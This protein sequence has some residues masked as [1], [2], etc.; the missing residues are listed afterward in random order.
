M[1]FS[2]LSLVAF[3][4][5]AWGQD[6]PQAYFL[7]IDTSASMSETP[8]RPAVKEDWKTSKFAEIQRQL[9][10]FCVALP[11]ET[12]VAVFTF[13]REL[14]EGPRMVF[15]GDEQRE[16]LRNFFAK[17]TANGQQTYAWR[18][19]DFVL[20]KARQA[21]AQAPGTTARV[22]I[23][24]DGEDNDPS[25]PNLEVIL[26]RYRD[27]LKARIRPT[28]VT[29][30]FTLASEF[31]DKLEQFNF[32]VRP[33]LT[34]EDIIPLTA[35]FDWVPI[36]PTAGDDVQF[37]DRSGGVIHSYGWEFGDGASSQDKAPKRT[38]AK[39]GDYA[40][41]LTIK[42]PTG[43]TDTVSRRIHIAKPEPLESLIRKPPN[44]VPAGATVQFVN[45][46][47]G[48]ITEFHWEFGDG[49]VARDQHPSHVYTM[50]GVYTV[51]LTVIGA[52][53][54]KKTAELNDA[55]RVL[56][57][58]APTV[59]LFAPDK[60]TINETVQFFDHSS[61]L[62]D[63]RGWDFGDG[64][65]ISKERD[66]RHVY[67]KAGTFTV[68][69]TVRGPGGEKTESRKLEVVMPP[70][71]V[72]DFVTGALKPR[73]GDEVVFTDISS[74]IAATARWSFGDNSEPV[75]V[76][77][78]R[79][80]ENSTRSVTH[81]LAKPGTYSVS[82]QLTGP[83]G[84]GRRE[85]AIEVVADVRAPRAEFVADH[86]EGRGLLTVR[87]SNKS[88]GTVQRF[89][90]DFGD[91][92]APVVQEKFGDVEHTFGSG[93]FT[94]TLRAE[95]PEQ[96]TPSR[97]TLTIAVKKPFPWWLVNLWWIVPAV[98]ILLVG[99]WLGM[100][101]AQRLAHIRDLGP[102]TGTMACKPV[103]QPGSDWK[104]FSVSADRSNEFM[105]R[106]SE[107][108][109]SV[110]LDSVRKQAPAAR[111]RKAVDRSTLEESYELALVRDEKVIE[112][113]S[114]EPRKD[115]ARAGFIFRYEP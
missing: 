34:P 33:S 14:K 26:G 2:S 25:R 51:R 109:P 93:T 41:R 96:F 94:V 105:F 44:E 65:P 73:A 68:S 72:V 60:A 75:T 100:K 35:S 50:P 52:K 70:A 46:S 56:G 8:K 111:I 48:S 104:R 112:T 64:S 12:E 80:S 57:P 30:G 77:Y 58:A 61:G 115:L 40:V 85:K 38:F 87:F 99:A 71:P 62:I 24:T 27:E 89:V 59:D 95:G 1:W 9:R 102:I 11:A 31:K 19:L 45:E 36:R 5:V 63:E 76:D 43:A 15:T 74:G 79:P 20:E 53:Y 84:K 37:V 10:D 3:A 22:L 98:L 83:G 107:C 90:W 88:E 49:S 39:A 114:I 55:I 67:E 103:G 66:P 4:S 113:T 47:K 18:S 6:R 97:R 69:V 42:S 81:A 17:L 32:Q 92:S 91:G 110:A 28:Y 13:D 108:L 29:L 21:T 16:Q 78:S 54:D 101:K 86:T 7:L 106:P 82:L 23:Y